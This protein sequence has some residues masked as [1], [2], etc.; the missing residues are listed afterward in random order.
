MD[1]G[2]A[3]SEP[4]TREFLA[5]VLAGF[6]NELVPL[7]SNHGAEPCPKA[8]I[9]VGNKPIIDYVLSWID[10]SGIKNVLLIC[11]AV[12]RPAISHH[13]HSDLPTSLRIDIQTYDESPD[14]NT[15]TCTLLRHFA[16]RISEDFVIL[17]CDFIPPPSLS[18]HTILNKF[19]TESVSD[20]SIATA[21]WFA[22]SQPD[23]NA[24]VEDWGSL[25]PPTPIV[26]DEKTETLLYIDTVDDSDRNS[27]EMELRMSLLSKY[28]R[29]KLSRKYQDSHVYVCRRSVLE[30]LHEKEHF[31]SFREEFFPWLCKI[32][33]QRLK[34]QKYE[35]VLNPPTNALTQTVALNHSTLQ[36]KLQE[37]FTL[38]PRNSG[39]SEPSSPVDD[40]SDVQPSSLRIGIVIHQAE[41]G[42]ATRVNTIHSLLDMNR[43]VLSQTTYSPPSDPKSRSLIDQKAQISSDTIVGDSTQVS[44]RTTIKKSVIGKHCVIGKMVKIVGCVLLDHCVVEDG[45]KLDGC[46]LG[47]G[48]KVGAKAEVS[49]CVTQA[50]YEVD[51]G[52]TAKNEK[53]DVSDWAALDHDEDDDE[54]DDDDDDEEEGS[55]EGSE[56]DGE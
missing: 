32:Q 43:R 16:S 6:G 35:R 31:D 11:P 41:D 19:R 30:L 25:P 46:I 38:H 48:T 7:T 9:P 15:G 45:A 29:T 3:T 14:S 39:P 2:V 40:D 42:F 47:R 1:L 5:V 49:R 10:Q 12:H 18:L 54:D 37:K 8:L 33:Y 23:K 26:W 53:L 56:D 27:E 52:E 4:V 22:A 28:P 17:P 21:C 13:V 51:A 20:G 55:E 36:N 24:F 44:E 50:G 34:R